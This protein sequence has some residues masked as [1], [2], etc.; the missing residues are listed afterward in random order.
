M[1]S[2][3][4]RRSNPPHDLTH[5]HSD[6]YASQRAHPYSVD[7]L[8]ILPAGDVRMQSLATDRNRLWIQRVSATHAKFNKR[9]SKCLSNQY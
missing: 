8:A 2:S 7:V 9:N 3:S 5:V 4:A 1:R 6:P